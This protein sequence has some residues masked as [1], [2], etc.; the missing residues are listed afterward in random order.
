M[1]RGWVKQFFCEMIFFT[2]VGNVRILYNDYIACCYIEFSVLKVQIFNCCNYDRS[3]LS[4]L[5]TQFLQFFWKPS[6][7]FNTNFRSNWDIH[8]SPYFHDPCFTS[9]QKCW[10]MFNLWSRCYD[11]SNFK[12]IILAYIYFIV[13]FYFVV[14]MG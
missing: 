13:F 6:D 14:L 3:Q 1:L 7:L 12:P 2:N 8:V 11:I 10:T 5:L 4:L 9:H